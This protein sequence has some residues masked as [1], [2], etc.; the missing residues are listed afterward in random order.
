MVGC[1][2]LGGI[3][4]VQRCSS[5]VGGREALVNEFAW[6]LRTERGPP[7]PGQQPVRGPGPPG[8]PG[9]PAATAV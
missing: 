5:D 8:R 1:R 2:R 7:R 6:F 9:P 4:R 3:A